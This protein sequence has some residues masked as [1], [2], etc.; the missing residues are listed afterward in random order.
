MDIH[1]H[2]KTQKELIDKDLDPFIN[3]GGLLILAYNKSLFNSSKNA[4]CIIKVNKDHAA[5]NQEFLEQLAICKSLEW[6]KEIAM[7]IANKESTN[8]ITH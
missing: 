6:A 8:F 5:F 4:F 3:K 2:S 1:I 7:L